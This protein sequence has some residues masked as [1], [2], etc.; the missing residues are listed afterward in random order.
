MSLDPHAHLTV[1][2]DAIDA[3]LARRAKAKLTKPIQ[4]SAPLKS[5][6]PPPSDKQD[7]PADR[8]PVAGRR[9]APRQRPSGVPTAP[10]DSLPAKPLSER[11][12]QIPAG[13]PA[14]APEPRPSSPE[15]CNRREGPDGGKRP[16]TSAAPSAPVAGGVESN[17]E[18]GSARGPAA[19]SQHRPS[20]A[21]P[22]AAATTQ[23]A[24]AAKVPGP[25]AERPGA[26]TIAEHL[27][28]LTYDGAWTAADDLQLMRRAAKGAP[29]DAIC[30]ALDRTPREARARLNLLTERE[31]FSR[32]LVLAALEGRA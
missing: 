10:P 22:A 2:T 18:A 16:I 23:S 5:M 6:R 24:L 13:P 11:Q 3:E 12:A 17:S 27:D 26:L 31:T 9:T 25:A 30:E 8:G 32:T 19:G 1:L 15:P 20:R 21:V 4:V 14:A 28:T 7:Q 29:F